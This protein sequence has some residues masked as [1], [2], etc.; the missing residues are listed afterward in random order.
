MPTQ[1][2][3]PAATAIISDDI[4]ISETS[5]SPNL[6]CRQ[7]SSEGN[8][9]LGTRSMPSAFTRP[10]KMGHVRGFAAM[11]MLS[12]RFTRLLPHEPVEVYG[13]SLHAEL[14]HERGHELQILRLEAGRPAREG[15]R[16]DVQVLLL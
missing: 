5:K 6:S 10:S 11:P 12:W 3:S 15:L 8:T 1:R 14:F 13:L 9:G 16:R 7:K 2:A 4:D